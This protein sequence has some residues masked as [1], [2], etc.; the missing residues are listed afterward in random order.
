MGGPIWANATVEFQRAGQTPITAHVYIRHLSPDLRLAGDLAEYE[1][2]VEFDPTLTFGDGIAV[3]QN[4]KIAWSQLGT[5]SDGTARSAA[6]SKPRPGLGFF[7][8]AI[9]YFKEQP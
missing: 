7:P 2:S 8:C 9:A 4:D 5:K 3:G 1:W 6:L